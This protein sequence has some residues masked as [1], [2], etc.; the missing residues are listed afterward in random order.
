MT[1]APDLRRAVLLPIDMQQ[2]FDGPPWPPRWN[3]GGMDANGLALLRAWRAAGLPI[4]H[5]RHDSTQP[6]STLQTGTTG[7][8]FRPG[9]EPAGGEALIAKSVNAAFIG[10][11]LDERLKRLGAATV[12]AFGFS[13]DMCVSTT[14]RVGANLGYRMVV[15]SDACDCFDLPDGAGGTI[16]AR[17]VHAAHMATLA[18]EFA[19]VLAT[20]EIEAMLAAPG[21]APETAPEAAPGPVRAGPAGRASP[22]AT[23]A[24]AR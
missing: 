23:A 7:H 2:A 6:A 15:A 4:M 11:D 3:K 13:S 22:P 10:T 17:T 14:V 9:F 16:P 12:V 19:A 1:P 21:A 24:T 8:A 20:A 18:Y 5:V